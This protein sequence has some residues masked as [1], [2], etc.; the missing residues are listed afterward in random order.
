[1]AHTHTH[2]PTTIAHTNNK[3]SRRTSKA[4]PTATDRSKCYNA[5]PCAN[6]QNV[7]ESPT[8]AQSRRQG[9]KMCIVFCEHSQTKRMLPPTGSI[10]TCTRKSTKKC[11]EQRARISHQGYHAERDAF[12]L[13]DRHHARNVNQNQRENMPD[14]D[15][16]T[17]VNQN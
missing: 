10:P 8:H 6:T 5:Q 1:M 13:H 9:T 16:A 7:P 11:T 12:P 3:Y 4:G 14:Q 2:K 17:I 15:Y